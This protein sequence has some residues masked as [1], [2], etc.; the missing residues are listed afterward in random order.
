MYCFANL[1]QLDYNHLAILE[2][3]RAINQEL[4]I[5]LKIRI[6]EWKISYR[7]GLFQ[8]L[9][10]GWIQY[11]STFVFTGSILLYFY[12]CLFR[13]QIMKTIVS[14]EAPVGDERMPYTK[15]KY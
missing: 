5:S 15:I 10:N 7:P 6:D 2:S 4:E 11:I 12:D 8:V 1:V 13:Y 9:K 3:S 14:I